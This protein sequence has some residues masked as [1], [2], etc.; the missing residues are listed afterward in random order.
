M[1]LRDIAEPG[2][3]YLS[4]LLNHRVTKTLCGQ[5]AQD[6]EGEDGDASIILS[7]MCVNNLGLLES[8]EASFTIF[9]D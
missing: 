3:D 9:M 6:I 7:S 1:S 8:F 5:Y 4:R 2:S